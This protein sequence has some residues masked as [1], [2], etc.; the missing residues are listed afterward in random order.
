MTTANITSNNFFVTISEIRKLDSIKLPEVSFYGIPWVVQVRKRKGKGG[1]QLSL[2]AYLFCAKD[3]TL[4]STQAAVSSFE[5][6]SFNGDQDSVKYHSIP[7]IFDRPQLGYGVHDL[8]KWDELFDEDKKYVMNDSIKMKIEIKTEDPNQPNK[9]SLKFER[10]NADCGCLMNFRLTVENVENLMAVRSPQFKLRGMLM[11]LTVF[12]GH[13]SHV[14][15]YLFC[16]FA[17]VSYKMTMTAKLISSNENM[18]QIEKSGS[19]KMKHYEMLKLEDIVSWNEVFNPENGFI[20]NN[21]I[22]FEVEIKESEI[23][24][25]AASVTVPKLECCI[26]FSD[27]INEEIS[28]TPCGHTFCSY[29]ITKAVEDFGVCPLCKEPVR[30]DDLRRIFLPM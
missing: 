2:A 5:L 4:N 8:I 14:G 25:A 16:K 11:D 24:N 22:V 19:L 21:S 17:N 1:D 9:S 29:C 30:K 10:I 15:V 18:H 27:I 28:S 23:P 20:N 3:E 26:C 7:Y 13:T 12:K 6:L